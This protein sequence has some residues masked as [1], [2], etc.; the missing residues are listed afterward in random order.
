MKM[1]DT[2]LLPG[3]DLQIH[4]LSQHVDL[5]NLDIMILGSSSANIAKQMMKKSNRIELI[6]EDYESLISTKFEL[7]EEKKVLPKLMDYENTDFTD[8]EFDIIYSQ[9]S[10]SN[11]QRKN[12]LKEMKRVCKSEG[13]L[14]IGEVVKLTQDVPK[15]IIDIF[16]Q[17]D[18]DP[19]YFAELKKYYEEKNLSV[20]DSVDISS[21]LKEYYK[22]NM[23]LLKVN[24]P[25]LGKSE[26]S[27]YKKVL[28]QISHQS[29][30]Y[31]KLGGDK[32]IG[33]Y[34]LLLKNAKK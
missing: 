22:K 11:T 17:S 18:L 29:K 2:I 14:C 6:V 25:S 20:V 24:I 32:F 13:F 15:Y 19:I 23:D 27:Y 1:N 4:F 12:I 9:G 10:I 8:N 7:K 30:A 33:F 28:N 26:K 31:L 3:L 5:S 34:A 16:D 21:T